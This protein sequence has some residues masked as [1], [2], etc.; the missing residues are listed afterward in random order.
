[1][2]KFNILHFALYSKGWYKRNN[3]R[4]IWEDLQLILTLD[5]YSGK[6][7]EKGDIVGVILNQCQRLDMNAFKN[8][9]TFADGISQSYCWKYGYYTKG[10]AIWIKEHET[11][12]EYDYY[13]AIVR[14]CMSNVANCD[15]KTML[16]DETK[17]PPMPVY[18]KQGLS[19][20]NGLK[21][22]RLKEMFA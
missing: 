19:R 21:E 10:N 1:M 2:Q 13:E 9:S 6:Y 15:I 14:Y 17:H 22:K 4:T 7:M 11:L 20:P 16:G 18:T 12:P 5:N 8:L 3:K